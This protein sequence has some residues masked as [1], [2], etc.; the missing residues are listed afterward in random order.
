M[1]MFFNSFKKSNSEEISSF[2]CFSMVSL[3]GKGGVL[4]D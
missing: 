1:Q 4:D 3:S 2:S